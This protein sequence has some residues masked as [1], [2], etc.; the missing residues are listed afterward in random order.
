M[1]KKV[2]YREDVKMESE[3]GLLKYH[4]KNGEVHL[5]KILQ[6]RMLLHSDTISCLYSL[7]D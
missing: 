1:E 2:L 4:E 5:P 7:D 6:Q 3:T